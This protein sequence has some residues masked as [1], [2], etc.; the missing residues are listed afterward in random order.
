MDELEKRLERLRYNSWR[1]DDFN[2]ELDNNIIGIIK[3][4][5]S[6]DQIINKIEQSPHFQILDITEKK[7]V[8]DHKAIPLCLGQQKYKVAKFFAEQSQRSERQIPFL[9]FIIR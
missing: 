4:N 6:E 8:S 5:L 2:N 7:M 9:H 3:E 1:V